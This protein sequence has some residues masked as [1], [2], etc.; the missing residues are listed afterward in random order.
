MLY[1]VPELRCPI[2][3]I[4]MTEVAGDLV[5]LASKLVQDHLRSGETL[6]SAIEAVRNWNAG[7]MSRRE[8]E[9]QLESLGYDPQHEDWPCYFA[10]VLAAIADECLPD[11]P[12]E[13]RAFGLAQVLDAGGFYDLAAV[14]RPVCPASSFVEGYEATVEDERLV[15]RLCNDFPAK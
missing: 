2:A 8:A 11:L 10:G 6:A 7:L 14:L 3:R 9:A 15:N 5:G 13:Q 4:A 1:R 12:V